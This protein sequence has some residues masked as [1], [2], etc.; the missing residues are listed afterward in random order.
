MLSMMNCK[1]LFVFALLLMSA[2]A[3]HAQMG[4]GKI[5]EIEEVKK[6]KLIVMI[7]EPREKMLKRI[8]KKAKRGSVEDYKADL[9]TYNENVKAVVEKFWPF[10]KTGIQYKTY[11][12][13]KVLSKSKNK[14]YAVLICVSAQPSRMSA[15]FIY[16]EGLYWVKDVK[17][18]FEDRD[19]AMFSVMAVNTIEDFGSKPVYY[20]PLFDVFPTKAS[21]VYGLKGIEAYFD[22]RIQT[23]KNGAKQRDEVERLEEEMAKRAPQLKNKTLIIREEWLDE[24]LTKENLK[25]YYPYPYQICTREFMDDVVMNQDGKYA[26]GVVLPYVISGSNRNS[27]LYFQYVLDGADSQTMCAVRPS[28]G[29]MMLAGGITGKAGNRNFTIKNI[30]KIVEQSKGIKK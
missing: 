30:T 24:E 13:I 21:L 15:G 28:S 10:N 20:L 4:M 16:S 17:E 5:E 14:D 25:N 1:R 3:L 27:I 2:S 22:M 19:D 23:K 6:R 8:E 11:D 18:D 29:G 7:E 9:K 12:E 26:Y